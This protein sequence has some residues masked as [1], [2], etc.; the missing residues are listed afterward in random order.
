[1]SSLLCNLHLQLLKWILSNCCCVVNSSVVVRTVNWKIKLVLEKK[2]FRLV[3]V[4][5]ETR[6]RIRGC[7]GYNRKFKST[8]SLATSQQ[9][10]SFISEVVVNSRLQ[11]SRIVDDSSDG[12]GSTF[13]SVSFTLRPPFTLQQMTNA[14]V[15]TSL[16]LSLYLS[17]HSLSL[18]LSLLFSLFCSC[19]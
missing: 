17:S 1:M 7:R 6:L 9:R 16:P 2:V 13:S 19:D 5:S 15:S 14:Y 11:W 18:S 4:W 12:D 8:T 3:A 10:Q